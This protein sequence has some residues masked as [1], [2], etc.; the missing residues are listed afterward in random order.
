[1]ID[2]DFDELTI[3][4]EYS[5]DAEKFALLEGIRSVVAPALFFCHHRT[6]SGRFDRK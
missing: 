5:L 4:D 1:M 3:Q 6:A 2:A